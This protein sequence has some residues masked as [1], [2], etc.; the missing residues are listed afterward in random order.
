MDRF[1]G[2]R[3]QVEEMGN[4]ALPSRRALPK[5]LSYLAVVVVQDALELAERF[6][7]N[8]VHRQLL[9]A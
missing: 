6:P 4:A 2:L 7:N 1:A 9:Y 5:L 8:P 3:E